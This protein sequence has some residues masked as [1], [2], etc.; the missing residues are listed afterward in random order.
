MKRNAK[1]NQDDDSAIFF[2]TGCDLF[3]VKAFEIKIL[4]SANFFF[5]FLFFECLQIER[6]LLHSCMLGSVQLTL[7]NW[8]QLVTLSITCKKYLKGISCTSLFVSDKASLNPRTHGELT[9]HQDK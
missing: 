6:P 9:K 7:L 5:F 2:Q 3:S 4:F 1:R 8:L